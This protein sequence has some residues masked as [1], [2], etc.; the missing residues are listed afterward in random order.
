MASLIK[1]RSFLLAAAAT[2][3]SLGPLSR[4]QASSTFRLPPPTAALVTRWDADPFALGAYSALPP[5]VSPS[6]RRTIANALLGGRA[7]FAGEYTSSSYP[8]T[9]NGAYD[10]GIR[11][12][13]RIINDVEPRSVIVIGAGMAGAAAAWELNREGVNVTVIEAR[14]RIG[15][16][17]HSDQRWGAPVEMGAAWIHGVR[18]NPVARLARAQ[19]MRLVR[20]NYDDS[21][22]RD[23]VT[24]KTSPRGDAA[25]AQMVNLV[26]R[27]EYAWPSRTQSAAS[28]L[29]Q[30]GWKNDRFGTW[31]AEV[32]LTQEYG[33]GPA[34]L[35]VRGPEEGKDLRGGDVF[36]GGGY[37]RIPTM[38]L[39]GIDVRL[40]TPVKSVSTSGAR[41]SVTMSDGS[42][43]H[44]DAVVIAVPVAVLKAGYISIDSMTSNVRRAINSLATGDLEK[45]ILRYDE[46]WWPDANVIGVVGGGV[47]GAPAGS[48][49]ALR[50]T[51]FYP[52]TELLGF[53]AL[54]GFSGGSASRAR[55]SSDTACVAE[56]IGALNAAFADVR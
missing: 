14:D 11:A 30:R 29:R 27:L 24:G 26:H 37:A 2:T 3:V 22:T 10:S 5:G 46:Q 39:A 19:G 42:Q 36:I 55:P 52:L 56:A 34:A 23:T 38:L 53:P 48:A 45:V 47:P 6:V 18:G 13:D 31:A 41:A 8:A 50:W 25:Q 32:E 40:S 33:L 35:G 21:I 16:R 15:G 44:A 1:R 9:T 20:T 43:L 54:V 49:A 7:V 28:W 17:I 4:I 51:E 12:A